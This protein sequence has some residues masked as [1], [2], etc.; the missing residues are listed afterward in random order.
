MALDPQSTRIA[1]LYQDDRMSIRAVAAACAVSPKTVH[2]RLSAA[3]IERRAPGGSARRSKPVRLDDDQ[4]YRIAEEYRQGEVSLDALGAGYGVSGD[5]IGRRLRRRGVAVRPPG[6]TLNAARFDEASAE[7]LDL[8]KQGLRPLDIALRLGRD[9]PDAIAGSLRQ[10]GMTPH[11]GRQ[12]PSGPDLTSAYRQA[13]TI[14]AL[15]SRLRVSERRLRAA[16]E[17]VGVDFT[18]ARGKAG[19]PPRHRGGADGM[20][21][22]VGTEQPRPGSSR[23]A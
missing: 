23:A 4:E 7:V 20:V 12:I 16:L 18:A 19:T 9:D 6:R 17:A 15:A 3:G 11:R 10:A 2:R 14:R 13:G 1:R 21:P 8:H 22:A 5:T